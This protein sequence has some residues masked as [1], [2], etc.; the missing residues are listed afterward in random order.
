MVVRA[1][2]FNAPAETVA[3]NPSFVTPST[4]HDRFQSKK[5]G[6]RMH[7]DLRRYSSEISLQSTLGLEPLS[8]L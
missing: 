4:I 2:T 5:S 7:N 1:A 6:R 3:E 8:E